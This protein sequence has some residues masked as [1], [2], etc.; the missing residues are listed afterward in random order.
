MRCRSLSQVVL[1]YHLSSRAHG[2]PAVRPHGS[3]RRSA[4]PHHEGFSRCLDLILRSTRSDASRRMR[5]AKQ[6]RHCVPAAPFARG[7]PNHRS[8]S[9]QRAQGMPGVQRH[10]QPCV[11]IR[12][13]ASKSPQVRRNSPA[14]PARMVLTVSFVVSLVIG[15]SIHTFRSFRVV[16]YLMRRKASRPIRIT[17][18]PGFP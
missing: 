13:H 16:P 15:C 2:K 12:K 14:F 7:L 11:Q 18:G 6:T 8:L 4:S 9:I 10:P 17:I 5:P 3:R 1:I